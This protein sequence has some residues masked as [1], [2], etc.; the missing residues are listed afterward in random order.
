M[1]RR[2]EVEPQRLAA[3]GALDLH[4]V[5]DTRKPLG[6]VRSS[7]F[8]TKLLPRPSSRRDRAG[9]V[10]AAVLVGRRREAARRHESHAGQARLAVVLHAVAVG[11][12]EDLAGHVGAVERRIRDDAHRRG[13]FAGHRVARE[14]RGTTCARL[15]NSPSL[16]P[17][18]TASSSLHRV[19][20]DAAIVEAAPHAARGPPS[21]AR[22]AAPSMRAEPST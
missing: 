16:T 5:V 12:V 11:V 4:L 6:S 17:A 19:L 20:A 3:R 21:S 1:D 15:T 9:D 18:P 8:S 22:S 2:A 7:S 14:R 13:G 10:E